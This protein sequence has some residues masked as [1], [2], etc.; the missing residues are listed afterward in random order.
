MAKMLR[1]AFKKLVACAKTHVDLVYSSEIIVSLK[2]NLRFKSPRFTL[3]TLKDLIACKL[4]P[5]SSKS[6]GTYS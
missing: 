2:S 4:V 5:V 3:K 6:S 1:T